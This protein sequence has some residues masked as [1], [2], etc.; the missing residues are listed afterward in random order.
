[1]R[2]YLFVKRLIVI[3][4][5]FFAPLQLHSTDYITPQKRLFPEPTKQLKINDIRLIAN[6]TRPDNLNQ[7]LI[8]CINN[9]Q[10][11][12]SKETPTIKHVTQ[13]RT[14]LIHLKTVKNNVAT[15]NIR[16]KKNKTITL[17][18][19]IETKIVPQDDIFLKLA[20]GAFFADNLYLKTYLPENEYVKKNKARIFINNNVLLVKTND[21]LIFKDNIWQ[22]AANERNTQNYPLA[23]IK[24]ITKDKV[25][26][27]G[28]NVHGEKIDLFAILMPQL[29]I[30][31][32]KEIFSSLRLRSHDTLS[33]YV[34]GQRMVL[35]EG[36]T[37][38]KTGKFWELYNMSENI[39]LS[40]YELLVIDK[41]EN[42]KT[43]KATLFNSTLSAMQKL[44][45]PIVRQTRGQKKL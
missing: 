21:F 8:L 38:V 17:Q 7:T 33:G 44:E 35:K 29:N 12:I 18:I 2:K 43:L 26:V 27:L 15:I 19:P 3:I 23:Q 45:V 28:W 13:K 41:I 39:F 1:M 20:Q 40:Q 9:K 36:M 4:A 34:E 32:T 22:P 31:K 16:E 37:L 25:N 42:E 11:V 24:Q 10:Y 5:L 6:N 14:L 30:E